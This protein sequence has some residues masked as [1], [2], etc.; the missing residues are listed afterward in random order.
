MVLNKMILGGLIKKMAACA[1]VGA[2]LSF[3]VSAPLTG[4]RSWKEKPPH[5]NFQS[6]WR[7]ASCDQNLYTKTVQFRV[8]L[9]QCKASIRIIRSL[10]GEN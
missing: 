7:I 5:S 4:K 9:Q 1:G 2:R 3:A 6:G 10:G 8:I